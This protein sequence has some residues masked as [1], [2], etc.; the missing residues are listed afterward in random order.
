[1]AGKLTGTKISHM[2][3]HVVSNLYSSHVAHSHIEA[4]KFDLTR[5]GGVRSRAERVLDFF[6][7]VGLGV[8][9][10]RGGLY[11]HCAGCG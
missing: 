3:T 8:S 9:H 4:R 6:L 10:S 11:G 7:L 1:M 2:S 5:P